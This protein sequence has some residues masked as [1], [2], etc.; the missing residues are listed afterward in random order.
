MIEVKHLRMASAD[1]V[2]RALDLT[3]SGSWPQDES[4]LLEFFN[5]MVDTMLRRAPDSGTRW[6]ELHCRH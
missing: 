5:L 6:P 2:D 1:D 4:E 3:A